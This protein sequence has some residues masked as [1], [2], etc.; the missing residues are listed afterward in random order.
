MSRS[1]AL[2]M[3]AAALACL[4]GGTGRP[5]G[6]GKGPAPARG[7]TSAEF[8]A[9]KQR[10][11][12]QHEL[13]MKLTELESEH[14]QFLLKLLQSR[15]GA[16]PPAPARPSAPA[17]TSAP[18][19]TPAPAPGAPP[20]TGPP[21]ARAKLATITGH[22]DVKGKAWGPVYVYVENMKEAAVDRTVEIVQRDRS[23][24]P[25]VVAVQ[26]GT[27]L[28]FP[29]ADPFL[30]NVFSPSPAQPFD[31]GTYRQGE[32]AGTVRLFTPGLIEVL[33]NMHAKMRANV[34]VVPNRHYAKASGDGNFRLENVPV[35]ARTVV[36][37][38]PDATPAT[39]T[40]TLTPAGASVTFALQV[41]PAPP[42]L[43][44]TGKPRPAY[45]Q[46]E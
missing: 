23:F 42:P 5:E 10:V 24:V 20:D 43:D 29:N 2:T 18:T 36:A 44:K 39:E 13:L 6:A 38:T 1:K 19:A 17:A 35:G 22:V 41:A 11:D 46:E 12:E 26:R 40:V 30:H 14:Y 27:R 25:S 37:W 9:L 15:G 45:R 34:L 21:A 3:S 31:L 7:P 8:E 16:A 32:A 28:S 4:L 33:C